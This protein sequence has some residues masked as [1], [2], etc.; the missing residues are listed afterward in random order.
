MIRTELW[1]QA[2][3]TASKILVWDS[4]CEAYTHTNGYQRVCDGYYRHT[5]IGNLVVLCGIDL[6]QATAHVPSVKSFF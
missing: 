2:D 6:V 5:S 3:Y 1:S 4:M